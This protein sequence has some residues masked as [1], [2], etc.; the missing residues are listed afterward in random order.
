MK[1]TEIMA[2]G[3][4]LLFL[5]ALGVL[6][7]S[8]SQ[9]GDLD[10]DLEKPSITVDYPGGFP[11]SC[12]ELVK[13]HTYQF[14][15]MLG[16]NVALASY[17]LDIHHNFD[18]HTH[19]DQGVPCALEAIKQAVNPWIFMEHFSLA[20]GPTS[21]EVTIELTL[22]GDIDAGDYHCAFSVTDGT[23][24]QNRTS[25]DIKIKDQ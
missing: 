12:S 19:D 17:S 25:M 9:E 2:L 8:C 15:A 5:G 4:R 16:D 6:A 14:K 22:P 10:R 20:D 21:Q 18:H 11:Q 23:G 1:G 7:L 3:Q 24:W 13:G